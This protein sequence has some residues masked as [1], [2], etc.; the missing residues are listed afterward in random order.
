MLL[1][2]SVLVELAQTGKANVATHHKWYQPLM[3]HSLLDHGLTFV[4]QMAILP[5]SRTAHAGKSTSIPV[6]SGEKVQVVYHKTVNLC[7]QWHGTSHQRSITCLAYPCF[8]IIANVAKIST[9]HLLKYIRTDFG[10]FRF[11]TLDN[12]LSIHHTMATHL[13][14]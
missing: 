1:Y 10:I 9:K 3:V 11:S 14:T 4:Y 2:V 6:H 5:I 13:H 7:L 12:T 8:T